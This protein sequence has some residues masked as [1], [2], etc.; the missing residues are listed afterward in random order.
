[1][2]AYHAL[3]SFKVFKSSKRLKL[4]LHKDPHKILMQNL[5][6]LENLASYAIMYMYAAVIS[7]IAQIS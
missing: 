1:M 5:V 4:H 6:L 3:C 2:S 7:N